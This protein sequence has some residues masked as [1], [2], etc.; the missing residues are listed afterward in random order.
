MMRAAVL[1]ERGRLEIAEIPTPIPG[2]GELLL[3]VRACGVCGSDVPRVFGGVAYHYPLVPGHEFSGVVEAAGDEASG[4]WVG[5]R[6]TVFPLIPCRACPWCESGRYELCDNYGYLGSRQNG[7]FAEYVVVPSSNVVPL[8]DELS[9]E[10]GALTEPAAVAYHALQRAQVR[11]GERVIVFG[12][13]PV[14][15]LFGIWAHLAGA[16]FLV[17]IDVD[18]DKFLLAEKMGFRY[19]IYPE[20]IGNTIFA[21]SYESMH[22]FDLAVEASGNGEALKGALESAAKTGRV[23]LLGNQEKDVTLL[24]NHFSLILRKELKVLGTWNS[25]FS[26]VSSDWIGALEAQ[27]NGQVNLEPLLSHTLAL[28]ELPHT[29]EKMKNKAFSY[30][31]VIIVF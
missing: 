25:T 18:R 20:E 17:G 11:A 30:T 8:P 24:P 16:R 31:K 22:G 1:K 12:L 9:Y 2:P 6:V 4:K 26:R 21:D 19:T 5:K 10:L 13:G 28:E 27:K 14:G 23:M 7:A 29:L 3:R 15:I